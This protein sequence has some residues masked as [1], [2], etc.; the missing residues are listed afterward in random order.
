MHGFFAKQCHPF[1]RLW[2]GDVLFDS[3]I[4]YF[5]QALTA[6]YFLFRHP[7]V[8]PSR[9]ELAATC[10]HLHEVVAT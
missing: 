8:I 5:N 4:S 7:L 9:M 1:N 2:R 6:R 10:R 3:F